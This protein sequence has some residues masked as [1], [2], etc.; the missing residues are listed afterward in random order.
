VQ[1]ADYL[2]ICGDSADN[3]P[4]IKGVGAKGASTL[5]QNFGDIAGIYN[6]LEQVKPP[7]LKRK[8]EEG[9]ADAELSRKLSGICL[10]TPVDVTP[11]GCLLEGADCLVFPVRYMWHL[12]LQFMLRATLQLD[13]WS[14]THIKGTTMP[15]VHNTRSVLTQY[16]GH[17]Q[18]MTHA[19]ITLFAHIQHLTNETWPLHSTAAK[20][21]ESHS[22]NPY[23]IP[24]TS[25]YLHPHPKLEPHL[26]TCLCFLH[27]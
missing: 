15:H 27:H 3:Y 18:H 23:P 5:L 6:S 13:C 16:C 11:T 12:S 25:S 8:L 9:R 21:C 26:D 4:G 10:Q 7:G 1:V 19:H 20:L 17:T 2:A 24:A 14:C 22:F